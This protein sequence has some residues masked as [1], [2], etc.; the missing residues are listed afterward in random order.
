MGEEICYCY[1]RFT[2]PAAVRSA[3]E[4]EDPFALFSFFFF[5]AGSASSSRASLR[6]NETDLSYCKTKRVTYRQDCCLVN[7]RQV[8][9]VELTSSELDKHF[10]LQSTILLNSNS[11]NQCSYKLHVSLIIIS[12]YLECHL[13]EWC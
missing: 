8:M 10:H 1:F 12:N 3:L 5:F 6:S 13:F 9:V 2:E 7:R 11:D 4:E